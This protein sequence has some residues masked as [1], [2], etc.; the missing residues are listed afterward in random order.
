MRRC[1]QTFGLYCTLII[2][3]IPVPHVCSNLLHRVWSISLIAPS[4]DIG[5]LDWRGGVL[6][7]ID[8]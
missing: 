3:G 5:V 8:G 4:S 1:V 2:Y 7:I 6:F